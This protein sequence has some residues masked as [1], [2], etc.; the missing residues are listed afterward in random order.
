VCSLAFGINRVEH[1]NAQTR[2]GEGDGEGEVR[3]RPVG[4]EELEA[5]RSLEEAAHGQR[6]SEQRRPGGGVS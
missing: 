4:L 2:E 6:R 5:S 1:H 3:H